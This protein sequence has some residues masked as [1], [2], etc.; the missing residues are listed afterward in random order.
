MA[1]V[2]VI[3]AHGLVLDHLYLSFLVFLLKVI[4]AV[5][6]A[7]NAGRTSMMIST[8]VGPI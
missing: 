6:A 1:L 8:Y 5:G 3:S 7:V 4:N 2:H